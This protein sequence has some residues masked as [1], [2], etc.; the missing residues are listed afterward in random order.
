MTAYHG[1][2]QH[3]GK[4]LAQI[5][6]DESLDIEDDFDFTIKGYC[7]PFAGMLGVYQHIPELF[8]GHKPK[9]KYKAGDLNKSV[10]LMWGKVQDGWKPPTKT[11]KEKYNKLRYDGKNTALKGF[12]GHQ[13]SF[14]GQYFQGFS[15]RKTSYPQA[16]KRVM[17]I[18]KKVKSVKFSSGSYMQYS[19]LK[20][21]IIYCDP[22]YSKSNRY[23]DAY[24]KQIHFNHNDF[25]GITV[26]LKPRKIRNE[27]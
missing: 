2:K 14:G 20:N 7:E 21:F 15:T 27:V 4:K 1:G 26:V 11:T 18:G 10:T 19:K 5:I 6:Y 17:E 3:I 24:H 12:I 9:L 25:W 8:E 16:S 13:Y 23:Y 22:P